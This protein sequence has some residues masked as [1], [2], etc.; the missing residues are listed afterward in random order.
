MYIKQ[1]LESK[2]IIYY[3]IYVDDILI[4]FEQNKTDGKTIM[5]HINNID[6]HL[7]FK[8]LEE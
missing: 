5:N 8:L 1:W 7:E 6:K 2:E 3:I 4:I